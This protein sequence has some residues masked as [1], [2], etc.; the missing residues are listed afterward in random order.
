MDGLPPVGVVAVKN[1]KDVPPLEGEAGV[2]A[3]DLK[4][5][6]LEVVTQQQF[7]FNF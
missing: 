2:G 5:N 3:R 7:H 1:G 4:E 6:K